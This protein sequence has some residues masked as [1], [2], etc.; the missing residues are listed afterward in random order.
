MQ[1]MGGTGED[2]IVYEAPVA[3]ER[4][5]AN[6]RRAEANIGRRNRW[7]EPLDI[8]DERPARNVAPDLCRRH[9]DVAGSELPE[10]RIRERRRGVGGRE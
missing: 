2:E 1:H 6:A 5:G 7:D 9:S 3:S 10:A 8:A 4:L